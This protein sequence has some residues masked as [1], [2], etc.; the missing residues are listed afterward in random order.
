VDVYNKEIQK[1]LTCSCNKAKR[2]KSFY[3]ESQKILL[4]TAL[5]KNINNDCL[6]QNEKNIIRNKIKSSVS[7]NVVFNFPQLPVIPEDVFYYGV[8]TYGASYSNQTSTSSAPATQTQ[9]D[10]LAVQIETD[11]TN[12]N[13]Q[14]NQLNN[15]V[16]QIFSVTTDILLGSHFI[17]F[18][19]T[20]NYQ[21][22]D[23]TNTNVTNSFLLFNVT[24]NTVSYKVYI[25]PNIVAPLNTTNYYIA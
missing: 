14:Q 23:I 8:Y 25:L 6:T 4:L 20:Q 3:K 11:I 9:I 15:I 17:A 21:I 18:P 12:Y 10:E 22:F 2:V 16:G 7:C 13:I 19:D 1:L 24:I 5:V